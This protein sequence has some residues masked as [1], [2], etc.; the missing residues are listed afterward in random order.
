MTQHSILHHTFALER[1]YDATPE[2]VFRAFADPAAKAQWFSGPDDWERGEAS[3]DFRVGGAEVNVGG[4]KGG[5]TSRFD[6]RYYDIVPNERIVY[7]YEMHVDGVKL[8]VSLSTIELQAV[9]G[10]TR[11][12][13]TEQGAFFD[14]HED[15]IL[16]EQGTR[17]MLDA[18]GRTVEAVP[19]GAAANA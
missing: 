8:S 17:D 10:G 12:V 3:M 1:I 14:G 18:L 11:L 13:L 9:P 4:P 19:T 15:P 2:R 16:R 5:F 6:A 7:T